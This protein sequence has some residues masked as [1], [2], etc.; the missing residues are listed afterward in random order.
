M[1]HLTPE[2]LA[3]LVDHEPTRDEA[4][5]L[6]ECALCAE[7]LDELHRQTDALASLPGLLPPPG[8]W[9]VLEARLRSEGLLEDP[10][11]FRRLGLGTT[12]EWMRT[13][14]ALVLFA[15]G[16]ALGAGLVSAGNGLPGDTASGRGVVAGVSTTDDLA[17]AAEEVRVAEQA[18]MDALTNYRTLLA[19]RDG[20]E[21]LG[22]PGTR[23]AALE[24]LLAAGQAA[25]RQAPADPFLNGLLASTLA[26]REMT[27]RRASTGN[28]LWF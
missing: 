24:Y 12:P 17:T 2:V 19:A 18:Y 25:V 7:E 8:D 11:L 4:R 13:A 6:D 15:S 22:D 16:T 3:R 14:A 1:G 28:D 23:I 9:D 27:L 20:D 26:E 5:H 10:G 21:A